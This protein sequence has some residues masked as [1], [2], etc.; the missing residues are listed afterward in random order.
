MRLFNVFLLCVINFQFFCTV[1]FGKESGQT[2]CFFKSPDRW[3]FI[4]AFYDNMGTRCFFCM[5]PPV[6]SGSQFERNFF[7][8]KIIFPYIYVIAVGRNKMERLTFLKPGFCLFSQPVFLYNHILPIP[9]GWP[10]DL[11]PF[12]Q[13]PV[14]SK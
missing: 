7:I 10:A 14:R 13:C 4:I 3:F 1:T 12:W 11:L 8:L 5:K 9:F 6:V 2:G